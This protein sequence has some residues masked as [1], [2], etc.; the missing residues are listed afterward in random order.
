MK[1]AILGAGF[2]G[3]AVAWT[4][5]QRKLKNTN[6]EVTLFDAE[7]IASGASGVAAGLLHP[8]AGAHAKLNRFGYEGFNATLE[9]LNASEKALGCRPFDPS[10]ILRTAI[11]PLQAEEFQICAQKHP[12]DVQLM[13]A[14]EVEAFLPGIARAPGILIKNG[15]TIYPEAYLDGLFLNCLERGLV[16][17]QQKIDSL[18]A[19]KDFDRIVVAMGADCIS[20]KELSHLKLSYT[21]GQILELQWPADL[22]PLPIALN[23]HIY[24][25][26]L[27][28]KKRCLVGSTYEKQF[29]SREPDWEI[30][31]REILPKLALLYPPLK[32]AKVINCRTGIRVSGP[33]HL[34]LMQ[35]FSE[36]CFV[37]TGMGSKGLLYHAFY[38]NKLCD[39]LEQ[40]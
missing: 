33:Q 32:D 27:P 16:F 10:G 26:M 14:D 7:G 2:S 29:A 18:D 25:V 34:P 37:L 8:F 17:H 19:L 15:I 30:A 35:K 31:K 22:P 20:L 5:L 24:C 9:L 23:S 6:I 21:K 4:L 3:L 36:R 39:L 1:I 28:D 13:S 12:Q 40:L 11:S 38:A